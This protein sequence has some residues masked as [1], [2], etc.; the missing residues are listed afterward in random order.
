MS[1]TPVGMTLWRLKQE[2]AEFEAS[3][4]YIE[5]QKAGMD[6]SDRTYMENKIKR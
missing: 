5:F 4:G 2:G 1:S 6:Y 3:L